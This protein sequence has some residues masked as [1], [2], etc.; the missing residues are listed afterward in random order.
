MATGRGDRNG[1]TVATD[2]KSA[3]MALSACVGF[4]VLL[5]YLSF[6]PFSFRPLPLGE[7]L[8]RFAQLPYLNLSA[9]SRAD[10]AANVCMYLPL[11]WLLARWLEPD[12]R[13]VGP[14]V[15]IAAFGLGVAWAVAVEFAQL[16]FR[17]R[18]VSLNDLLAES[19]GTAIGAAI[20]L[21]WG[22]PY[23]AWR[24]CIADGGQ[25]TFRA[26]LAAYAIAYCV[27]SLA[28]LDLIFSI[29]E[30]REHVDSTL[31]GVWIAPAGCGRSTCAVRLFIEVA[32]AVPVGSWL[33]MRGQ[34][35][36]SVMRVFGLGALLGLLLEGSQLL[37]VSG[38]SQGASVATCAVGCAI[39]A[40]LFAQAAL[41]NTARIRQRARAVVI[42][43]ALPYLGAVTYATG[44]WSERWE[45][46]DVALKRLEQV[47]WLPFYY[48]YYATEQ[49]AIRS[50]VACGLLY[51][52]IGFAV[53]LWAN[54]TT[55]KARVG[56]AAA[57]A[58]TTALLAEA[59]KLFV[60]GRHPDP[61]NLLIATG[62]AWLA[63][64]LLRAIW[65]SPSAGAETPEL[66]PR[67]IIN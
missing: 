17:N 56:S 60:E 4:A 58:A 27:L 10:W 28:P 36:V 23:L 12:P 2:K 42:A 55:Q 39:G 61:S 31:V 7:A 41:W 54:R 18:T 3:V 62:S 15:L 26:A 1:H 19:V 67:E 35:P 47:R 51:A 29:A 13:R 25:R 66:M 45:G 16:Y 30:L 53:S 33:A 6:I 64:G 57:L 37:L 49:E 22:R 44:W 50:A 65:R 9:E 40:A 20:W 14:A 24:H 8:R 63:A 5:A 52:P 59:G 43:A 21:L 38:V 46:I 11:G 34:R 32:L 48:H